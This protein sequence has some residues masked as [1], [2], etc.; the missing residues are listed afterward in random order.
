MTTDFDMDAEL[1][2]YGEVINRAEQAGDSYLL[3]PIEDAKS[4]L[5]LLRLLND[6]IREN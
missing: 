4:M 6:L 1:D 5:R 2:G 3:L